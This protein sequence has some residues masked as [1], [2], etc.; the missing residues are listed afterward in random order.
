MHWRRKW[1]PTPVFLPGE[2]HGQRSLAS[3]S[4]WNRKESDMTERLTHTHIWKKR[5]Q[6]SP[7]GPC[8]LSSGM[9]SPSHPQ[10]LSEMGQGGGEDPQLKA[11]QSSGQVGNVHLSSQKRKQSLHVHL[12]TMQRNQKKKK[13]NKRGGRN[14]SSGKGGRA[15]GVEAGLNLSKYLFS[16]FLIFEMWFHVYSNFSF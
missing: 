7:R 8:L 16:C 1:Q 15:G 3:Y 5:T 13:P 4:P 14:R 2:S 11:K 10:T 9:S 6:M 12:F